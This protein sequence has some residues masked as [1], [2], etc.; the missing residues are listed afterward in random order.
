MKNLKR[1]IRDGYVKINKRKDT[2]TY[3]PQGKTRKYS[4]PEEKIQLETYLTLLYKYRYPVKQIRVS[5][6]VKIGSSSREADVVV[7]HDEKGKDPF[8]T[9]ECK[10]RKV[11]KNVFKEAIDQGFSYAAATNAEYVWATSGDKNAY[12][13]VWDHAINERMKNRVAN[14][15]HFSQTKNS[16][17]I[18]RFS[19]WLG[20]KPALTDT[21][22]YS[23]VLLV[24]MGII[25]KLVVTYYDELR[26]FVEPFVS[27]FGW[28]LNWIFNTI[29][30]AATLLSLVFGGIFMRSHQFFNTPR[31][32]KRASYFFLALILFLPAWYMGISMSDPQWWSEAHFVSEPVKE[33]I[34]FLP[35]LKSM[36]FT[37]ILVFLLIT[38]L[39]RTA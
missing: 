23:I 30:F 19:K 10:K 28:Q 24:F 16:S 34:F 39:S 5:D 15:P 27:G 25:T 6:R 11:S 29:V 7:Y 9:I 3:L 26:S 13:E 1:A 2:V 38:L 17:A 37:F 18:H 21:F 33:W 36:P 14:I 12:F 22:L 31:L 20:R 32:Q 8:I 4:N 35:Y